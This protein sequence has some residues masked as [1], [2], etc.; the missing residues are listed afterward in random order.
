MIAQSFQ[1]RGHR[2]S[3]AE[4]FDSWRTRMDRVRIAPVIAVAGSRGKTSVVR[5]VESIFRE[6]G[7]RVASWTDQG[8]DIEGKS[9]RGE[10]GPWARALTSLSAGGLDVAIQELDWATVATLGA[11][12]KRFPVI[13]ITNLCANNESCLISPEMLRARRSLDRLRANSLQSARL[14]LNADDYAVVK[15]NELESAERFLVGMNPDSPLLRHHVDNEGAACWIDG[16]EIVLYQNQQSKPVIDL[17]WLKWTRNG[18][19]PFAVQTALLATAIARG[20]GL[21][22]ELIASGLVAHEPKPEMM[23][24]AFNMFR[25]GSSQIVVD[26]PMPPWFLK[27][28]LRAAASLATGRQIHVTGPMYEIDTHEL[29]AI[30]R[31]LGRGGSVMIIHGNWTDDRLGL[32]RR[33]AA[34]NTVPPIVLQAVSERSAIEQGIGMLRSGDVLLVLAEDAVAAVRVVARRVRRQTSLNQPAAG[35]A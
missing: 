19:I 34:A 2:A 6:A 25:L 27:R 14:I 35:A 9:Q 31:L 21:P 17:R 16:S 4:T 30:G 7:Y 3:R 13:A 8:V 12:L 33:G 1:N 29:F 15:E 23:P 28:T 5:A 32:I 11:S 20:C 24:G 18:S 10:L 26:R 22:L